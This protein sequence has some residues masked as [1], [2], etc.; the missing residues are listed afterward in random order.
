MGVFCEEVVDQA[1][2]GAARDGKREQD[3]SRKGAK[4]DARRRGKLCDSSDF[5]PLREAYFLC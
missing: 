4:L 3:I 5:A 2:K 1:R